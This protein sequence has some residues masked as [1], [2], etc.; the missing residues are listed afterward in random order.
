MV[1]K[2]NASYAIK[3]CKRK[4]KMGIIKAQTLILLHQTGIELVL[5]QF[6]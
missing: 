3:N 5:L 2:I 1:Q 4:Y 6:C